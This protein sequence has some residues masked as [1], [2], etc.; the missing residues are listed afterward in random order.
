MMDI[1]T[2]LPTMISAAGGADRPAAPQNEKALRE[3]ALEFE[4]FFL[5]QFLNSMSAGLE[6]DSMFGG[7]EAEQMFRTMLNEEYARSMSRNN[8]IGIADAVYRELL[9]LQEV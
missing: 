4:A 7:G 6:A 3:A 8:G 1:Q 5:S 9:A 2:L